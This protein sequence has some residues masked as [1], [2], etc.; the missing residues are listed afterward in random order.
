MTKQQFAKEKL[1]TTDAVAPEVYENK[2]IYF[3]STFPISKANMN[4]SLACLSIDNDNSSNITYDFTKK[5]PFQDNS[6]IGF[7]SQ[8]Q[9]QRI[10]FEKIPYIFDD[11]FRCLRSGGLFRL[12]LPDYNSPFLKGRSI[13]D[14]DGDILYYLA[15]GGIAKPSVGGGID[16]S[17]SQDG[18][19][20]LWF[21]TYSKVLQLIISSQIRKCTS[22]S[23][24]VHHAWI[25]ANNFVCR[26]FDQTIMPVARTPPRDKRADGKPISIVVDF[27]K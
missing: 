11:I 4:C 10:N 16:V 7:Q 24:S 8:D 5:L 22:I 1:V 2:Y 3:E 17:F 15:I 6:V 20:H 12:S 13:Y 21:P 26:E 27:T 23:I 18:I 14:A 9:F 25:D 19:S